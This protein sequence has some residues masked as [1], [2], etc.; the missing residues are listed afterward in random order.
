MFIDT[1]DALGDAYQTA[2]NSGRIDDIMALYDEDAVLVPAPG[3]RVVGIAAIRDAQ[4][5]SLGMGGTIRMTCTYCIR[6]GD[7]ALLQHEWSWTDAMWQGTPTS[8]HSRTAEVARRRPD[9][10]WRYVI[11][12]VWQ[13]D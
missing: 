4:L 9:G 12:H 2:F 10:S 6:S 7:V 5:A 1:P 3:A 13:N 8:F 11:D